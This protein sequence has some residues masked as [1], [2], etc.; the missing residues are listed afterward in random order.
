MA[1]RG[2]FDDVIQVDQA[3]ERLAQKDQRKADIVEL[4]IFAGLTYDEIADALG[5]S[6]ATVRAEMRFARAWLA[7]AID[8]QE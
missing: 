7:S 3:L 8:R 6:N 4:R 5:L 1:Q 2:S